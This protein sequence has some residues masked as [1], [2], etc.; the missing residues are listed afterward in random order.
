MIAKM[1]SLMGKTDTVQ[2]AAAALFKV[3][4]KLEEVEAVKAA[5]RAEIS[6]QLDDLERRERELAEKG[7]AAAKEGDK[8]ARLRLKINNLLEAD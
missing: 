2:D 4:E 6:E 1:K 7:Q 8:A 3:I 5:E